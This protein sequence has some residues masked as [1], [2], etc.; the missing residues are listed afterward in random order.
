MPALADSRDLLAIALEIHRSTTRHDGLPDACR[1]LR[2]AVGCA[3][4]ALA[5]LAQSPANDTLL[6]V[7][8]QASDM[9]MPEVGAALL[10]NLRRVTPHRSAQAVP[11]PEYLPGFEG[12]CGEQPFG[13]ALLLADGACRY[14]LAVGWSATP[15]AD[16]PPRRDTA[17]RLLPH[18]A[19]SL[20]MR[21]ALDE[22][23]TR[24]AMT[25]E[26][27]DRLPYG[28][29]VLDCDGSILLANAEG[30]RLLQANDGLRQDGEH[31][32]AADPV[33]RIALDHALDALG[34]GGELLSRSLQVNRPSHA[35]PYTV[36]LSAV[37]VA[38]TLS[39]AAPGRRLVVT[40]TDTLAR[41]LPDE[42]YLT[43]A[44]TLTSA[45]ARIGRQLAA[46][47]RPAE[48][49]A[50]LSVSLSTVRTHLRHIYR[51]LD[52]QSRAEL[53]QRLQSHCWA[54]ETIVDFAKS[55]DSLS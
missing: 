23:R 48:I 21:T 27:L 30:R 20:K 14:V 12:S 19:E 18:F 41:P 31:L 52:V 7:A 5:R 49:A 22:S 50:A 47:R 28:F 25:G 2:A 13:A 4:V 33:M 32:V 45:E 36:S 42:T 40:I 8:C 1:L 43:H 29:I 10:A 53:V 34:H 9:P 55:Q 46:G 54:P 11:T 35:P 6:A 38:G 24:T 3:W 51:K 44:F 39:L 15:D 26:I 37:S 17:R 16:P